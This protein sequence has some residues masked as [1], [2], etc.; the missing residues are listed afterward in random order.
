LFLVLVL[1]V[2][3]QLR[4][5]TWLVMR[6]WEKK[7]EKLLRKTLSRARTEKLPCK[8]VCCGSGK[9]QK[10]RPNIGKSV[11]FL[12]QCVGKFLIR[13]LKFDMHSVLSGRG[14]N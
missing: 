8:T 13:Q 5:D 9:R 2:F 4:A 1:P 10:P 12:R 6:Y 11:S 3:L 7:P 14:F